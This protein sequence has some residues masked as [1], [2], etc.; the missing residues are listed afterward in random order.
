[1]SKPFELFESSAITEPVV[2]LRIILWGITTAMLNLAF[3]FLGIGLWAFEVTGWQRVGVWFCVFFTLFYL[4]GAFLAW[5]ARLKLGFAI[6]A[7]GFCI[8]MVYLDLLTSGNGVLYGVLTFVFLSALS[9]SVS[10]LERMHHWIVAGGTLGGSLMFLDLFGPS[11]RIVEMGLFQRSAPY[12]I[13]GSVLV[14]II[15]YI[16]SFSRSSIATR[17]MIPLLLMLYS[18]I[19]G[20]AVYHDWALAS[21]L[22]VDASGSIAVYR[23]NGLV[24]AASAVLLGTFASFALVH[25]VNLPLMRL[26][27]L[28]KKIKS[29][30]FLFPS[31]LVGS[32]E[33]GVI[34][35]TLYSIALR[36]RQYIQTLDQRVEEQ[37]RELMQQLQHV[38]ERSEESEIVAQ[39]IKDLL[40][41]EDLSKL[42]AS[43]TDRVRTAFHFNHVGLYLV[44]K[45][46]ENIVLQAAGDPAGDTLLAREY[47]VKIDSSTL[48]SHVVKHGKP[49][50]LS[51]VDRQALFHPPSVL[52]E[53]RAELCLPLIAGGEVIGVLDLHSR[54]AASLDA[55]D[56]SLFSLLADQIAILVQRARGAQEMHQSL[57]ELQ[58]F[59]HSVTRAEWARQFRERNVAGY[60]Y[61]LGNIQAL[62]S[63]EADENWRDFIG[64]GD[65][66]ITAAAQEITEEPFPGGVIEVPSIEP[67]LSVPIMLRGEIIGLVRLQDIDP[68]REWTADEI[69]LVKAVADQIGLAL[70]N[71]R[72][73]EETQARAEREATV[74]QIASRLRSS[75]DPR[76]IVEMAV[77]E[78]RQ[79]LGAKIVQVVLA[80]E[81]EQS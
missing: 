8:E 44:D 65:V 51:D 9:I 61:S 15:A 59:Q 5:R 3:S 25:F 7:V 37:T 30:R 69:S 66:V 21:L 68:Q 67:S 50:L 38:R 35:E 60:Y 41:I 72:L 75:N 31:E 52:E 54:D 71:A 17:W 23:R 16:K 57:L 63:V 79:A 43:V 20:M 81:K 27:D 13:F 47:Q 19:G 2:T 40:C 18:W 10:S 80:P 62:N 29:G 49:Y 34:A 28:A 26:Y 78:L 42:L 6:L 58:A 11:N 48:V 77:S 70:E 24:F 4:L 76:E 33:D 56:V 22:G 12:I 32:S 64:A 73:L 14:L 74:A 53:T 36:L 1:M 45:V 55:E 39:I 46:R